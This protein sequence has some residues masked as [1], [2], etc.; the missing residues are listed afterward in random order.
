MLAAF[1]IASGVVFLALSFALMIVWHEPELSG[2]AGAM[3]SVCCLAFGITSHV[4]VA[5]WVGAAGVAAWLFRWGGPRQRRRVKRVL[6]DK[7][8]QLRDGLVR[9]MHQRRVTRPVRNAP[10]VSLFRSRRQGRHDGGDDLRDR[11]Y[12]R[13]GNPT[14]GAGCHTPDR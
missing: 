3:C 4:N 7:S 13:V 11:R 1:L 14:P 6:G 8:R 5:T 10:A 2:F 12:S 9:R